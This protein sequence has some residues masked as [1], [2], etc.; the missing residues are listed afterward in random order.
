MFLLALPHRPPPHPINPS[1]LERMKRSWTRR[2]LAKKGEDNKKPRTPQQWCSS[3]K[4]RW[5]HHDHNLG[6]VQRAYPQGH[7]EKILKVV[8]FRVFSGCL[9]GIFREFQSIFRVFQGVC[10]YALS[11]YA[12]WTHPTSTHSRSFAVARPNHKD[13]LQ[14]EHWKGK[15]WKTT[16]GDF[17]HIPFFSKS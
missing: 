12:L 9:R 15:K 7:K 5:A 3:H 6:R 4:I 2:R 10:P 14:T 17:H 8:N 1:P 13:T 11:G 16:S